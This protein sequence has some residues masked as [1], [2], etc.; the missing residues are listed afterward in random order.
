LKYKLY[1]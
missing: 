1:S